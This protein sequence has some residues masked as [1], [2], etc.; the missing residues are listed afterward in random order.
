MELEEFDRAHTA[1]MSSTDCEWKKHSLKHFA[2]ELC[3][4][5]K[6][7]LLVGFEYGNMLFEL[8]SLLYRRAQT[9]DMRTDFGDEYYKVLYSIFIKNKDFRL[10]FN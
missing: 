4:R 5:R 7:K 2:I 9:T 8:I 3:Q 6:T 1:L 10:V